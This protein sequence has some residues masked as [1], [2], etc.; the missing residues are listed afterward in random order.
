MQ[1][2]D[3][4]K[5]T[6]EHYDIKTVNVVPMVEMM[7]KTA[8]QARNLAEAAFIVD[9][10]IKDPECG[11]ILTLAGSLISAGQR[12]VITDLMRHNM[13]DAIV[14]TGA[15][16]VDQ[17]FFEALGSRHYQGD[18][19]A[20]DDTL[21][22]L[23][24]DRIYDTY[25]NEDE[26]RVCDDVTRQIADSLEPGAYSSR[27]F[28]REMGRYLQGRGL[29]EDSIVRLAFELDIPIFVP[30]F[31]DCS[32][33]FGLV[34]HQVQHPDAHVS[35]DS[36]KDFRELTQ[37]K[38]EHGKTGLFMLGGGVPKNFVQDVVVSAEFLGY[39]DVEMHAYAVQLTV[40]DERDGA[41]SG[42][43]LKE[44]NSWGKVS[45]AR[46]Q[47]VFGEM[48][49]TLPLIAGYAYHKR[50]WEGRQPRRWA[51]L[52]DKQLVAR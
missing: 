20:S 13:V 27:E 7:A 23:H 3:F 4:L 30:A 37:I 28:I 50:S 11:V 21:R 35:I 33:G 17:D 14:S 5:T 1:Q 46:E 40:A 44:A 38:I 43:T 9:D 34:A 31:S 24:I 18:P 6:V 2:S 15:N 48:T 19:T 36:V 16:I 26:L 42:S 51:K 39:E 45:L 12:R 32:A 49:V 8:F 29:G 47:M 41:L 10:M 25:I 22:R 52:L